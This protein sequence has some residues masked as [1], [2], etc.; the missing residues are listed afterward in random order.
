MGNVPV[1]RAQDV[2]C[3]LVKR[4][5]VEVRS[6]VRTNSSGT[7]MVAQPPSP[8][9]KDATSL[10]RCC[11]RSRKTSGCASRRSWGAT[12]VPDLPGVMT[13]GATPAEARTKVQAFASRVVAD[14]LEP[15]E[16]DSDL[17]DISFAT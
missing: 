1:L 11:A 4:G 15:G 5:F 2:V 16:A 13:Y 6:A 7:L 3:L 9:I 8:S 17:V 12:D 14:R 10:Q